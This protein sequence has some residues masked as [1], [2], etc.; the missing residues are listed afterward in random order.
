MR[1]IVKRNFLLYFAGGIL[2]NLISLGHVQAGEE[3]LPYAVITK[4]AYIGQSSVWPSEEDVSRYQIPATQKEKDLFVWWVKQTLRD[5]YIPVNLSEKISRLAG[6]DKKERKDW[7]Y[8][9]YETQGYLIQIKDDLEFVTASEITLAGEGLHPASHIP[10]KGILCVAIEKIGG[11]LY[12]TLPENLK[13]SLLEVVEKFLHSSSYPLPSMPD[14][15][16]IFIVDFPRYNGFYGAYIPVGGSPVHSIYT[17]TDGA[18]NLFTIKKLGREIILEE[19]AKPEQVQATVVIDPDKWNIQWLDV[20]SE[21]GYV[22]CYIGNVEGYSVADIRVESIK[23]NDVV[24]PAEYAQ[25]LNQHQS[26]QG[27]VL[28]LKFN[29]FEAIRSIRDVQQ[30]EVGK[31]YDIPVKGSLSNGKTFAAIGKI[32]VNPPFEK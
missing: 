28:K 13:E 12:I 16:T 4:T 1:A 25:I 24:L 18:I 31:E 2:L 21:E 23:M 5:E 30:V 22:N 27:N 7:F 6:W 26:F 10:S 14:S 9:R 8:A 20:T 17:W 15:E 29:K 11:K 3:Y 32:V 19:R